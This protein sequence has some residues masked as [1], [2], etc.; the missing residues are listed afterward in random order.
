M[1][2]ASPIAPSAILAVLLV[3]ASPAAAQTD[4]APKDKAALG[5]KSAKAGK[6]SDLAPEAFVAAVNDAVFKPGEKAG[7]GQSPFVMKLQ[8]LLDRAHASPGVIDGYDGDNVRKAIRAYRLMNGLPEKESVDEEMWQKLSSG[9]EPVLTTYT[10]TDK[11]VAGPFVPDLPKDYAELSKLERIAYRGPAEMLAERF[12]LDEDVLDQMNPDADLGTPG[13]TIT[14]PKLGERL[15]TPVARLVADK[16][17]KELLG[18]N[19]KDQLVVSYPATI[20]SEDNPSP[21]GEHQVK[22]IAVNAEYWYRPDVNFKQGENDKNLRLPPGPNNPIGSTWIGLDKPTY[23]IHG[24]PEPSKI[25]KVG[26]H[27]CVRLTNWNVEELAKL[28]KK[29]V[30]VSFQ[31]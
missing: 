12:H 26:S 27:G 21:S 29:G 8:I 15:K 6:R 18:Y 20:G 31:D 11:D 17:R 13:T 9:A 25:D 22:A 7:S 3:A 14:V 24:T 28:V 23:G 2:I 16:A 10:L 30:N 1:R 19:D 5:L 4:A